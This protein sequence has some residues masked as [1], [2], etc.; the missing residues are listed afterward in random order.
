MRMFLILLLSVVYFIPVACSSNTEKVHRLNGSH[1]DVL[2][3]V[4]KFLPKNPIILEA[5]AFNGVDSVRMANKWPN[6]IIYAFEPVQNGYNKL[7]NNTKNYRNISCFKLALGDFTGKSTFFVSNY[8][9]NPEFDSACSSI[10]PPEKHLEYGGNVTFDEKEEVDVILL[11]EWAQKYGVEHVD[12]M[13]LDMQG[14]ELNML[15]KSNIALKSKII[16][17]EM[18]FIEAYQGQFLYKD[19]VEWMEQNGFK[20]IAID[21]EPDQPF[22]KIEA[23]EHYPKGRA[24]FGNG[25]FINLNQI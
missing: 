18:E 19:V 7:T 16:Y 9:D 11:D 23:S 5:G 13:W 14:Y 12:F 20:L 6:S 1:D 25:V 10:L 22:R 24:W 8:I 15:K 17:M 4:E 2:S 21:F 3:F